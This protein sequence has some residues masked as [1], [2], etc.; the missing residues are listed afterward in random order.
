MTQTQKNYDEENASV[1]HRCSTSVFKEASP[2]R[3]RSS[4][5]V[6]FPVTRKYYGDLGI[7]YI[8]RR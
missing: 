8:W 3:C 2:A 1:Q 6:V 4:V 7:R 5:C